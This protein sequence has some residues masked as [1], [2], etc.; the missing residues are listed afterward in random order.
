MSSPEQAEIQQHVQ[1]CDITLV[2]NCFPVIFWPWSFFKMTKTIS[3]K[4]LQTKSLL[5]I[6]FQLLVNISTIK[7]LIYVL[8]TLGKI[9]IFL[10]AISR[11]G[12]GKNSY[13][14]LM[15][16]LV[17]IGLLG[18][19]ILARICNLLIDL[20]RLFFFFSSTGRISS[21]SSRNWPRWL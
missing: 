5:L 21:G 17:V 16:H 14:V 15:I 10:A 4:N 12:N 2:V 20:L 9:S 3:K 1:C 7:S 18:N 11:E 19:L 8:H 6:V 13:A